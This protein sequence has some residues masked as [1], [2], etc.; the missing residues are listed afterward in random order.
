MS[1]AE[2]PSDQILNL[3]PTVFAQVRLAGHETHGESLAALAALADPPDDL[4]GLDVPCVGWLRGQVDALVDAWLADAHT[5]RPGDLRLVGWLE[6]IG[7]CDYRNLGNDPG[8]YLSGVYFVNEPAPPELDHVRSD[9]IPSRMSFFDPRVG[10]N[11]LAVDG[12]PYY[13][14]TITVAPEA[15]LLMLWPGYVRHFTRVHLSRQPWV[16]VRFFAE[17]GALP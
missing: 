5:P 3:W 4:F 17:F 16:M 1:E 14:Q 15:G 12:D 9:C 2:S 6:S 13:S 8:A 7:F 11:A 10:F